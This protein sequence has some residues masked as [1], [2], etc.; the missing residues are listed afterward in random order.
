MYSLIFAETYGYAPSLIT[1]YIIF[2]KI[3]FLSNSNSCKN[4]SR[5][6]KSRLYTDT[7]AIANITIII[8]VISKFGISKAILNTKDISCKWCRDICESW[9]NDAFFQ[10]GYTQGGKFSWN[11]WQEMTWTTHLD[12]ELGVLLPHKGLL[13]TFNSCWTQKQLSLLQKH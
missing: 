8:S 5:K 9:L 12:N 6:T 1:L 2:N 4:N 3:K 10:K 13:L 11:I 7:H